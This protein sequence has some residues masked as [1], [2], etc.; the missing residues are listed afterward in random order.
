M[1]ARS[2]LSASLGS[3]IFFNKSELGSQFSSLSVLLCLIQ[4]EII[5]GG[6][7]PPQPLSFRRPCDKPSITFY[8]HVFSKNGVSP[9]PE[10]IEAIKSLKCHCNEKIFDPI[11]NTT[12]QHFYTSLNG[13]FSLSISC[14]VL[15]ILRFFETCKLGVSD[16]IYSRIINYIYQMVNIYVNSWQKFFKL[17]M[18]IAIW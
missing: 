15:E 7:K 5:G 10:K 16:V 2:V 8:G 17:C 1:C 3:F 4:I 13:V 18:T 14:L 12:E 9:C 11:L 6:L